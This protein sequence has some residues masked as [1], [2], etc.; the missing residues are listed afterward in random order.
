MHSGRRKK[1]EEEKD[2]G[3]TARRCT[4]GL[5]AI[6]SPL[7][8]ERERTALAIEDFRH[9]PSENFVYERPGYAI[10]F[11]DSAPVTGKKEPPE[12][13]IA[14]SV[15]ERGGGHWGSRRFDSRLKAMVRLIARRNDPGDTRKII[16]KGGRK[17]GRRKRGKGVAK[18][19][20]DYSQRD[21]LYLVGTLARGPSS[22]NSAA[23]GRSS[24]NNTKNS[25]ATGRNGTPWI[26]ETILF[27]GVRR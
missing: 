9:R 7:K 11:S 13:F 15:G 27:N 23:E 3:W 22:E 1:G 18:H 25:R 10:F 26:Y 14:D 19:R 12:I 6:S 4:L 24:M 16:P 5:D 21:Y 20:Q 17:T 2:R 8:R